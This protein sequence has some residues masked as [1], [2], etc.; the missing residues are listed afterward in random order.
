V[1]HFDAGNVRDGVERAGC[2]AD[3][4]LEVAL[5]RFLSLDEG[6]KYEDGDEQCNR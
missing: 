4:Q 5:A 3:R 1:A 2:P 6:G